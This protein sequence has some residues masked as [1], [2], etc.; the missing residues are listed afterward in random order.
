MA[1]VLL[2]LADGFEEVEALTPADLLRRAGA[3]VVIAGLESLT[4]RGSHSITV[5]SD[6]L[7]EQVKDD[8][9]DA[10]VLPGGM[11][12]STN[13]AA[14]EVLCGLVRRSFDDGKLVCAICAAP[15]VVL[16]PLG[17]L[18][19]LDAVCY[20]SCESYSP[21]T[22]FLT[23]RKVCFDSNVITAR[24]AGCAFEFGLAIIEA[25]FN[26]ETAQKVSDSTI[27]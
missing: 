7:L 12:G 3:E 6:V 13:L 16:G 9:F 14:S 19:G 26:P 1:R 22:V 24:G 18:D 27:H 10:V 2:V 20:P 15:A 11:P 5:R 8:C 17:I 23:D 21:K 25:L 4:V